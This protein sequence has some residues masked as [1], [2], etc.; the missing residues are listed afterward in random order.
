MSEP[1]SKNW[2]KQRVEQL[3]REIT[4]WEYRISCMKKYHEWK[5]KWE[6]ENFKKSIPFWIRWM[7]R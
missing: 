3:E 4:G 2:Y 1:K 6:K 7:I 5:L